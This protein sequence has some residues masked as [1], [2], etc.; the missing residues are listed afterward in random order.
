MTMNASALTPSRIPHDALERDEPYGS[1]FRGRIN[2]RAQALTDA[3]R[4]LLE[5]RFGDRSELALL[6]ARL[7][8]IGHDIMQRLQHLHARLEDHERA[9]NHIRD[10]LDEAEARLSGLPPFCYWEP[11][12]SRA[13]YGAEQLR[14][15]LG[16]EAR[17]E[18]RRWLEARG[19][20]EAAIA[21]LLTAYTETLS[22]IEAAT[23]TQYPMPALA[24]LLRFLNEPPAEEVIILDPPDET[25]SGAPPCP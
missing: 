9:Q 1:G 14:S 12:A 3:T 2:W 21:E 20:A 5:V 6:A 16:Q 19:E 7:R 23:G 15:H 17:E 13:R 4:T 11:V 8:Q 24:D 10:E 18:S 22:K 25:T